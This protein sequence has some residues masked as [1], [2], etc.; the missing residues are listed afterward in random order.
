[1][2]RNERQYVITKAQIKKFKT[3]LKSFEKQESSAHPVLVKAQKDAMER[4][5]D[6][7]EAQVQEYEE[8]R[9]GKYKV[10]ES[11]SFDNLPIDLIRARIALGLTQKQ[12]AEL[13]GLKEQQIQRYEETEYASA[14][15]SRLKEIIKVL[16][17]DI[18][19]KMILPQKSKIR[20][21][22]FNQNV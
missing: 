11:T 7:L 21:A 10:L 14:S 4:Q 1:M 20:E 17:I 3:A 5:L 19:E 6:E 16:K 8:L 15:F 18:T 13:V 12:L 22:S 9:S 2:I